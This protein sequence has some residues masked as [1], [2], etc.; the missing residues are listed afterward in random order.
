MCY[1]LFKFDALWQEGKEVNNLSLTKM[2][3]CIIASAMSVCM[4]V[5]LVACGKKEDA[6]TEELTTTTVATTTEEQTT[7][8]G[9]SEGELA[10]MKIIENA[11]SYNKGDKKFS[12]I[13]YYNNPEICFL[14][15]E[16]EDG[17][18]MILDDLDEKTNS[19]REQLVKL[20]KNIDDMFSV[21]DENTQGVF[22]YYRYMTTDKEAADVYMYENTGMKFASGEEIYGWQ[23]TFYVPYYLRESLNEDKKLTLDAVLMEMESI[24]ADDSIFADIEN[25]SS[26]Y[27]QY[28]PYVEN[29]AFF[30]AVYEEFSGISD[31][32]LVYSSPI[33]VVDYQHYEWFDGVE[34]CIYLI[35]FFD[36]TA[37]I[38]G[39]AGYN[40][41]NELIK[42]E[43]E[44]EGAT[45]GEAT[46]QEEDSSN[47]ANNT[48]NTSENTQPAT[49]QVATEGNGNGPGENSQPSANNTGNDSNNSGDNSNSNNSV[50][51]TT[52][53]DGIT[54]VT[55][56]D[57]TCQHEY[58]RVVRTVSEAYS[59]TNLVGVGYKC[60]SCNFITD[61]GYLVCP[62]CNS[63]CTIST[64]EIFEE[65]R[66]PAVYEE[67]YLCSKC[68][69]MTGNRFFEE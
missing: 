66:N 1:N 50:T 47:E 68:G 8:I 53:S 39:L 7:E 33:T 46:T 3:K 59:Y 57:D 32:E 23:V 30:G 20:Y 16:Y 51:T 60:Y 63:E 14:D 11:E 35:P 25:H 67:Y 49:T 44:Y 31:H 41:D 24:N 5:S 43:F 56:Q 34:G 42:V 61:G 18:E 58:Q 6:S 36:K 45:H 22:N 52:G 38:Y 2:K 17:Y 21:E 55:V 15:E 26:D 64:Y 9:S 4:L 69:H 10:A 54:F 37:N 12:D 28:V 29:M 65:V 62:N 19:S 48:N 27:G 40:K 13:E